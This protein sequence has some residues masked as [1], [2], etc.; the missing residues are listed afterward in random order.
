[1][2]VI[3]NVDDFDLDISYQK[4]LSKFYLKLSILRKFG[5]KGERLFKRYKTETK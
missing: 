1:M 2:S 4:L 5:I 3:F